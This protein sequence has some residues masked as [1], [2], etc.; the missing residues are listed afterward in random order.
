MFFGLIQDD[1]GFIT[2]SRWHTLSIPLELDPG[3]SFE[4]C[5]LDD[6]FPPYDL[7]SGLYSQFII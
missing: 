2:P 7:S 3:I 5:G 4:T 1:G 6:V